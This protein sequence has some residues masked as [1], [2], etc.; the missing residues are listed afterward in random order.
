M[1]WEILV[2]EFSS[3]LTKHQKFIRKNLLMS[4][5]VFIMWL[6]V[7]KQIHVS[8][9]CNFFFILDMISLI[10]LLQKKCLC[11]RQGEKD[12]K[13][14]SKSLWVLAKQAPKPEPLDSQSIVPHSLLHCILGDI[15]QALPDVLVSVTW[16]HNMDCPTSPPS[17]NRT[18][19]DLIFEH[20]S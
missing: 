15:F 19:M 20:T 2:F 8:S 18:R 7:C 17:Y 16:L 10:L 11:C 12:S 1:E 6:Y 4:K 9:S 3:S 5:L 14:V 13:K